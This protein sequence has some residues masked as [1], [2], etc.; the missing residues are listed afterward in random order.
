MHDDAT[1]FIDLGKQGVFKS[2][3]AW[4][5]L[6]KLGLLLGYISWLL[7]APAIFFLEE[8]GRFSAFLIVSLS[9]STRCLII[10]I[11]T[12]TKYIGLETCLLGYSKHLLHWVFSV[13]MAAN[14]GFAGHLRGLG[15]LDYRLACK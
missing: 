9:L 12:Y 10:D 4:K 8:R 5:L 6:I 15:C 2:G 7:W 14:M 1:F 11:L 13:T 3:R